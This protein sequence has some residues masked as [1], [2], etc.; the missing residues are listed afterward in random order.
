MTKGS[1]VKGQGSGVRDV[2]NRGIFITGTDTGVGKTFIGV[3]LIRALKEKGFRVCPMKPVETGCKMLKGGL[4]PEDALKLLRAAEVNEPIGS[5]NPYRFR[6]PLAP[7]VAAGL[8]GVEIRKEKIISAYDKL[9]GKYDIT[10]VEG[11]GGI[12]VPICK[13]YLC[14][15]LIRDLSLPVIIVSRP[16][17]GTINHTLLSIEAARNRGIDVIGVIINCA[18]KL[19]RDVS[20]RTNPGVLEEL[21]GIPV[22]GFIPNMKTLQLN[23][24][25]QVAERMISGF[26]V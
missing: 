24:F 21:T 3:G 14:L 11:A 18:E 6:N 10:I 12:M 16:G 22:L 19:K 7:S 17:L 8:E 4:V 2:T 9:S 25:R 20:V 5:V 13:K 15:D 1:R 26:S 23:V